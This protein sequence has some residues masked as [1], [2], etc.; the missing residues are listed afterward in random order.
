[1]TVSKVLSFENAVRPAA[2]SLSTGKPPPHL[3]TLLEELH[4]EP[5]GV[6]SKP[7][8]HPAVEL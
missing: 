8:N 3:P 7:I 4:Q 1:M 2:R 5:T 6:N